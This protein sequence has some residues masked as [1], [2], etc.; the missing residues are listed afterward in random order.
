MR[1]AYLICWIFVPWCLH[2]VVFDVQTFGAK[3]DGKA[4]D[5]QAIQA[6]IDAAAKVGGG[7]VYL[8]AGTY[9]SGSIFLKDNIDFHLEKGA[10]LLGSTNRV[11]YAAPETLSPL[12]FPPWPSESSSSAHLVI[13]RERKN[14]TVRGP[15]CIDGQAKAFL[16]SSD[17][18]VYDQDC[19]PWRPSQMLWFAQCEDVRVLNLEIAHS[20]Q[21]GCFFHGCNRVEMRGCRV[22]NN[23]FCR[24][25]F[26][27]HNG[28]GVDIDSCHDVLIAGC[29]IDA[30]DDAITLRALPWGPMRNQDCSQ[31][32]VKN[33]RLSADC[34]AIR[35]GVGIGCVRDVEI[36][37]V[38]IHETRIAFNFVS[39]WDPKTRGCSFE[40]IRIANCSVD[41]AR[42]LYIHPMFATKATI[43]DVLLSGI[44]G[45]SY[46]P[47]EVM[48]NDAALCGRILL[49]D[50]NL[51]CGIARLNAPH[52]EIEGGTLQEVPLPQGEFERR[53]W[54]VKDWGGYG[55]M[56]PCHYR[57]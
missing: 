23:R 47:G 31:I 42:F 22:H 45:K 10:T 21:W 30:A 20:T 41:C 14:V 6:A 17:G 49:K 37:N 36:S 55:N 16:V 51:K 5:T 40:N 48:W 53:E 54:E 25:T 52:L 29:D 7:E 38:T 3:G 44:R 15:G 43:R 9:I 35:L 27:T 26:H 18:K 11:D 2:A 28:D 24:G 46:L 13:C 4:N 8:P 12:N 39:S 33:C 50:I 19:I 34:D 1:R 57:P 32:R 56:G